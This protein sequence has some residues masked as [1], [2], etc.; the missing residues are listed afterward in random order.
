[1][2]KINKKSNEKALKQGNIMGINVLSAPESM[3]LASVKQKV[4]DSVKFSIV[5]PNPELVLMAQKNSE[6]KNA[7][8]SAD[9]AIP[10]GIGLNYASKFLFGKSINI[11]HGRK[12]F[13]ELIKLSNENK[14][15]VF[16]LGGTGNEAAFAASKLKSF[17]VSDNKNLKLKIETAKGPKLNERGEVVTEVDRKI[18]IDM[19]QKINK[20]APQILFVAFGNPKQ[21]IWI[22]NNLS[23]LNIG[24]AMAVGGTF[25][26]IAG[27]SKLPPKWME[28]LELEWV[29]RLITEPFRFKR[30]LNA[31]PIFPLK[32][33]WYKVSGH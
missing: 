24:G 26:Y 21:E 13:I 17:G 23:K 19:I 29:W 16:F 27:L 22:Y 20:F 1:M 18:E 6:L 28:K 8:N 4:S 14:W 2:K 5:T 30:I 32:V 3:V 12:L 15:K 10:D 11:I 7:L 25:R 9:F 33:F 31:F